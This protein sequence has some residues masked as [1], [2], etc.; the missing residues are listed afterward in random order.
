MGGSD[1]SMY[2]ERD[3]KVRGLPFCLGCGK[4]KG[5]ALVL[6]WDCHHALKRKYDGSY[7]PRMEQLL[8]KVQHTLEH[9]R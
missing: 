6:C 7:G 2:I 4:P 1:M 5:P 3:D 9:A 8:A